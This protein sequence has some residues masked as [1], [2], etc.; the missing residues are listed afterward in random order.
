MAEAQHIRNLLEAA[1]RSGAEVRVLDLAQRPAEAFAA[2]A[3]TLPGPLFNTGNGLVREVWMAAARAFWAANGTTGWVQS[4]EPP[5]TGATPNDQ[6]A[7]LIA[8]PAAVPRFVA[9]AGVALRVAAASERGAWADLV[10]VA[11]P[12]PPRVGP[13]WRDAVAAI[14]AVEERFALVIAEVDGEAVAGA[15]LTLAAQGALLGAAAVLPAHRGR[16]IQRALIGFRAA[17]AIDAGAAWLGATAV[18]DGTSEHNLLAMG[19]RREALRGRYAVPPE[20]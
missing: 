11:S 1:E 13:V 15:R 12:M 20:A 18:P 7:V 3:P 4:V 16:G 10:L 5:W 6:L 8:D 14:E 19:F 9:P 2:A 17:L